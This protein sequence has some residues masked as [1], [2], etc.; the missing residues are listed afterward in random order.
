MIR[1]TLRGFGEDGKI[2]CTDRVEDQQIQ[3]IDEGD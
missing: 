2:L 1:E 3:G